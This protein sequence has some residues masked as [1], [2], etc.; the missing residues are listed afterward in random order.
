MAPP[1]KVAAEGKK[2]EAIYEKFMCYCENADTLL[3]AAITAAETKIP[4]LESGIKEDV[5]M[6][7]QLEADLKAHKADRE[8]GEGAI[9]KAT[10]IREK[11]AAAFAKASGDLKTNIAALA[12]AIPAIQKGMG[13][14]LQTN[15][16]SVIRQLS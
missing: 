12:K 9:A 3:G 8:V 16:A 14:F 11:E 10:G 6:K 15:A 2:A 5:A 13:G 1:S 4:Q 7:K